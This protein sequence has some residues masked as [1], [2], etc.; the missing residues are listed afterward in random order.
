MFPADATIPDATIL[1]VD[2]ETLVRDVITMLLGKAG[3]QVLSAD[4]GHEALSLCRTHSGPI[5]LALLDVVM[6]GMK[7]PE[8]RERLLNEFPKIRTV[9][10]S[11]YSFDELGPQGVAVEEGRFIAKPF[12]LHELLTAVSRALE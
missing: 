8:L 7:G 5:H 11:G 10:I 6:P 9:F 4:S 2:D 1:V 12:T 3:Y